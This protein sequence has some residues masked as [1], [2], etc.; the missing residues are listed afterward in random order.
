ML[1]RESMHR[2]GAVALSHLL[3][4]G[5]PGSLAIPCTC[6]HSARYKQLRSKPVLTAV[7]PA[8]ALYRERR[9]TRPPG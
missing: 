3:T 2:A 7:G 5:P 1:V 8:A 6:G 4:E 9:F